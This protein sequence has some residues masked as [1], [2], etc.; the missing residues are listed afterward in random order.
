M[1][2]IHSHVVP[3][4]TDGVSKWRKCHN[5][6][7]CFQSDS[8]AVLVRVINAAFSSNVFKACH[9]K[10]NVDK[11]GIHTNP[12]KKTKTKKKQLYYISGRMIFVL[13]LE[14]IVSRSWVWDLCFLVS[15]KKT[16]GMQLSANREELPFTLWWKGRVLPWSQGRLLIELLGLKK[17][18]LRQLF[19][20]MR[21]LKWEDNNEPLLHL[22]WKASL[23]GKASC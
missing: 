17:P 7:I 23:W 1:A 6:C 22:E 3:K 15:M 4:N 21:L 13:L 10:L 20:C 2:R 12:L 16:T 9:M 11:L 8:D 19:A 18:I 14:N 5:K